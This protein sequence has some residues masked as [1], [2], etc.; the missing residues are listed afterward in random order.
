M[1]PGEALTWCHLLQTV[2]LQLERLLLGLDD[3]FGKLW[4]RA[5]DVVNLPFR[6]ALSCMFS[7]EK[8]GS[9]Y[10]SSVGVG[11]VVVAG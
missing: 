10:I 4:R 6:T 7:R 9:G 1:E 3:R 8:R 11:T 2:K 5:P